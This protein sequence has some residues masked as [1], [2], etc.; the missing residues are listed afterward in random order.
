[1]KIKITII[2]VALFSF[3][4]IQAQN[5]VKHKADSIARLY[6]QNGAGALVIGIYDN[7][8]ENIFYYG[9][10]SS[11][12]NTAPDGNTVFE[13]GTLTETFTSILYADMLLKNL[14]NGDDKLKSFLPVNIP[15]PVY[16]KIVCK[17]AIVEDDYPLPNRDA[18]NIRFTNFMCFPDP[19]SKPQEIM[20]CD[21]ATHTTGFPLYP[22]N[23]SLKNNKDNPFSNYTK[24][25]LY[26]F[27]RGYNFDGPFGYDYK[28]SATGITLLGHV[29]SLK[30]DMDFDTLLTTRL[31]DSLGMHNTRINLT[32]LQLQNLLPGRNAAGNI[33]PHYTYDIMAPYGGLHSTANDMMLFLSRNLAKQKDYYVNLLDYT[34]NGRILLT[35]KKN[36]GKEIALGWKINP[37]DKE[38]KIVWQSNLSGGFATYIGFVETNHTGV[39]I[40][41]SIAKD[42]QATAESILKILQTERL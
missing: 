33:V 18:G 12:K 28:H 36:V 8:K 11:E 38:N 5:N 2:I 1:M 29:L 10:I 7:G 26:D 42:T 17:A 15:S 24:E 16:Q 31:F 6:M 22:T 23:F 13:I 40:L 34:H 41:S 21:L 30:A 27:L 25:N 14:V 35:G 39:F 3:V 4:K 20:L 19:S 37:L 9:K 32:T